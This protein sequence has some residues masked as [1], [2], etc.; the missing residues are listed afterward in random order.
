DLIRE[1]FRTAGAR[2]LFQLRTPETERAA[3]DRA[4]RQFDAATQQPQTAARDIAR[5][6]VAMGGVDWRTL[7]DA[8]TEAGADDVQRAWFT[9]LV[10]DAV[11]EIERGG[12]GAGAGAPEPTPLNLPA[13]EGGRDRDGERAQERAREA[14][15]QLAARTAELRAQQI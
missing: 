15:E 10:S 14:A 5:A 13:D 9:Q 2:D 12:A 11:L 1:Q 8:I 6:G 4:G 7:H 3:A